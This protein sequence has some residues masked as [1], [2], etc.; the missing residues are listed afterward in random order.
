MSLEKFLASP[1]AQPRRRCVICDNPKAAEDA[2]VLA[3]RIKRGEIHQTMNFLWE[4]YF[5]P[6]YGIRTPTTLR[7][8]LR[9]C[10]G[11]EPPSVRAS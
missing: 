2:H 7:K 11:V 9:V 5:L 4:R 8:H 6:E 10:L 3:E 1:Q